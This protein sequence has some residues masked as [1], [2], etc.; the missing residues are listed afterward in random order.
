MADE[1]RIKAP[2]KELR[3]GT[4]RYYAPGSSEPVIVTIEKTM[5]DTFVR[6]KKGY[7]PTLLKDIHVEGAFAKYEADGDIVRFS[8]LWLGDRFQR[9]DAARSPYQGEVWTKLGHDNA[10]R[11]GPEEI[12]WGG[13]GYGYIGSASCSF[14]P[15]DFVKFIPVPL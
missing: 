10:R 7:Y 5:G 4:Y 6:F 2:F 14:E 1:K 9:L 8:D 13:K 11:H 12:R 3:R 15:D